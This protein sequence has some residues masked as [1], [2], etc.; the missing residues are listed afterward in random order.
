MGHGEIEGLVAGAVV[1]LALVATLSL[2]SRRQALRRRG[3]A[4]A[5]ARI[6][7]RLA[8]TREVSTGALRGR[9]EDVEVVAWGEAGEVLVQATCA[10]ECGSVVVE[11]RAGVPL[12][13][14]DA[15]VV[16][17]DVDAPNV[18]RALRPLSAAGYAVTFEAGVLTLRWPDLTIDEERMVAAARAAAAACAS[19]GRGYRG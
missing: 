15:T 16:V 14:G 12:A 7:E 3:N 4:E 19:L 11:M 10:D 8:L 5:W 2:A 18:V 1:V 9:I 6:C 17:G 13:A